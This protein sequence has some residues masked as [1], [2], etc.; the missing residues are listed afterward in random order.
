MIVSNDMNDIKSLAEWCEFV[1][2]YKFSRPGFEDV[3]EMSLDGI[4]RAK[5]RRDL[6]GLRI[7]YRDL[8]ESVR[9]LRP[10]QQAEL[11]RQLLERFGHGLQKGHRD[12][13]KEALRVLKRGTV[14]NAD[15][16]RVLEAWLNVIFEDPSKVDEAN[17]INNL[18]ITVKAPLPE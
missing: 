10:E 13:E 8:L 7:V 11:D 15:E 3:L 4:R 1:Q 5:E 17:C 2:R 16:Y 18:L 6:K 12:I 9:G 14:N